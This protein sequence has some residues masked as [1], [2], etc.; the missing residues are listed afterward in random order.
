MGRDEGVIRNKVWLGDLIEQVAGEVG[1]GVF[2]I[3]VEDGVVGKHVG[4]VGKVEGG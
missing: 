1:E 2:G 4:V 3:G